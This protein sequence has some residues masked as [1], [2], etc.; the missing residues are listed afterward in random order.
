MKDLKINKKI[1]VNLQIEGIHYWK[2]CDI[3]EV[4]YLKYPHR[5]IFY[6]EVH[7]EV[8]HNDRDIEIIKFKN[9]IINYFG[10]QPVHFENKSCEDIAEEILNSFKACYVKVLEDN[11]NGAILEL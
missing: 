2:D 5:H 1:V 7:K 9:K 8:T 10:S 4:S 6:I 3:E 11:E